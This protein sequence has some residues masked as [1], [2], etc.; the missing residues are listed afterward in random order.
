MFAGT[1]NYNRGAL[2]LAEKDFRQAFE[3]SPRLLDGIL[4]LAQTYLR[5]ENGE[6]TQKLLET[7][8][9]DA[10]EGSPLEKMHLA[11]LLVRFGRPRDG[12]KLGYRVLCS[13]VD[14]AKVNLTYVG[15]ILNTETDV[16]PMPDVVG[17][18]C[19]VRLENQ[20]QGCCILPR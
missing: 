14:S 19:W 5:A 11:Q 16:I 9:A 4:A 20:D 8:D 17:A 1:L 18:G 15:L 12:I 3:A 6:A 7:I 10:V 2:E 13:T